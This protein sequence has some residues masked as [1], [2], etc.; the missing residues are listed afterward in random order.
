MKLPVLATRGVIVFPGHSATLEAGRVMSINAVEISTLQHESKIIILS[1]KD[2]MQNE[3]TNSDELYSIGTLV[4][5]NVDKASENSKTITAIGLERVRI[6]KLSFNNGHLIDAEYEVVKSLNSSEKEESTFVKNVSEKLNSIMADMTSMPNNVLSSLA[7]GISAT[8][9]ADV[10]G[11]YLPL[12]LDQKQLLLETLDTNE[13]LELVNKFLLE[14]THGSQIEK[15]IDSQV[16]DQLDDQQREFLLREKMKAIKE[17][18]GEMS[19]KDSDVD[20]WREELKDKRFPKEVVEVTLLE[21]KRFEGMPSISAEAHVSKGYI[22]WIVK[23]PW[24][25]LSTDNEDLKKAKAT[26]DSH[27]FGLKKVKERIIEHLAVKI[28]TKS[29][30]SPI[31]TL[32]GPPGVGKTSLGKSIAESVGREF[33]KVSLGG[34]RDEAEIRGHRRTYVGAMPGKIIQA[35]NKAKTSNPVILLDEID[36]MASDYRGDP[37]AAMLEVLDPEQ[38]KNFQD[39]Y[40]ELEYDLSQVMFVAT[41]NYYDQIPG[42]LKDRVETI[43]I[44]QYTYEEKISIA[45]DYLVPRVLKDN[46]LKKSEFK[47]D[48]AVIEYVI[49]K[50]TQEAGVRGLQRIISKMARKIVLRKIEG[51]IKGQFVITEEKAKELLGNKQIHK[52]VLKGKAEVGLVNGMYYSE[53][54][55]GILPIEVTTFPSKTGEIKL[56]GSIKDVMK[57][58][59]SIA[60]GYLRTNAKK[61]G[62]NFDWE[63]NTILIHV[64]EGATPKDG[65]SAGTAF[66]TAL[67]SALTNKPVP[68]TIALTGEITLRGNVL[69]IGGLKEKTLGAVEA[70]V[71]KIFIPKVNERDIEDLSKK[72]T[73]TAKIIIVNSY[74]DIYKEIFK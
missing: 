18:L 31:L 7:S 17:E 70:G 13:R 37:T 43:F 27:H 32:V 12:K 20:K 47:I 39:H 1:Q 67:L 28:N 50:Y 5:I 2:V 73:D 6:N 58:S 71:K 23:L 35:I 29:T 19:S 40:L 3:V 66:T 68:K 57:E 10:I 61:Y 49:K 36:K 59:L 51:K 45:R 21:I 53:V 30:S 55:G 63:K 42:P 38:N 65:P 16:R 46:G 74:D 26:L 62:I 11:H 54:G 64:P 24:N 9:L 15:E 48:D 41:A 56:T 60:V 52:D 14:Q 33:I 22:D 69:P 44:D 25:R 72:V 34:V 8:D 4:S